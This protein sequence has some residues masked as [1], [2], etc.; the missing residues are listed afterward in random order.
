MPNGSWTKRALFCCRTSYGKIA[1]DAEET[2]CGGDWLRVFEKDGA[3]IHVHIMGPMDSVPVPEGI[4][5]P[6]MI[7]FKFHNYSPRSFFPKQVSE[8]I[9]QYY[10]NWESPDGEAQLIPAGA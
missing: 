7:M 2:N 6:R 1:Y 3:Q 9:D 4:V 8:L 5:I 10:T